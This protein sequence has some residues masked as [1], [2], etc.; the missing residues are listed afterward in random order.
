MW[1]K[2]QTQEKNGSKYVENRED[3]CHP[4]TV[5]DKKAR[6]RYGREHPSPPSEGSQHMDLTVTTE[7]SDW[8]IN[9]EKKFSFSQFLS[10]GSPVSKYSCFINPRWRARMREGMGAYKT[11]LTA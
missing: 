7:Y 5:S 9:E 6:E 3:I 8:A 4:K 2:R 10:S 1:T 11:E